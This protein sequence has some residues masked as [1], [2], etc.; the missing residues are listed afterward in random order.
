MRSYLILVALIS[1]AAASPARLY[2]R[3]SPV[4]DEAYQNGYLPPVPCWLTSDPAC[5]PFVPQGSDITVDAAAGSA[6]VTGLSS[7]CASVI[8]EE[9]AR[10]QDG[11]KT[12]GW[13]EKYGTLAAAGGVLRITGMSPAAVAEY[14]AL[15]PEEVV[16]LPG[17]PN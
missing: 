10:E 9:Q 16:P 2:K 13:T 8:A 17:L 5:Q 3:C 14:S 4:R 12:Y 7:R 11:R 15:R 1:L 6:T